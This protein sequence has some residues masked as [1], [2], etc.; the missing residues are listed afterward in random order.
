M[1]LPVQVK[2]KG[3]HSVGV[4][5]VKLKARAMGDRDHRARIAEIDLR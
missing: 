4:P 2:L 1:C 3:S 5:E